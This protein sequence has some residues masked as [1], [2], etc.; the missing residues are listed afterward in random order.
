MT[1]EKSLITWWN[2]KIQLSNAKYKKLY[3]KHIC[4][5]ILFIRYSWICKVIIC[6]VEIRSVAPSFGME[7][8]NENSKTAV[9][10]TEIIYIYIPCRYLCMYGVVLE[11]EVSKYKSVGTL[12]NAWTGEVT[13]QPFRWV[14][15]S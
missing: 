5:F 1:I 4:T 11:R 13:D 8:T 3:I 6:T 12:K 2:I 9:Y 15:H 14:T 7:K 10:C